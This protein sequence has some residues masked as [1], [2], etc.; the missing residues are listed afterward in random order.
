MIQ[1]IRGYLQQNPVLCFGLSLAFI[2]ATAQLVVS[3][4]YLAVLV[5]VAVAMIVFGLYR[6]QAAIAKS[7]DQAGSVAVSVSELTAMVSDMAR[8][9]SDQS[10]QIRNSLDQIRAVVNDATSK[11][12]VSFTGLNEKSQKQSQLVKG[13]IDDQGD[14]KG[15][16]QEFSVRVFV[17]ETDQ[18]LKQFIG[19]LVDSSEHGVKMAHTIDDISAHMD[20]A[21]KL[22]DDVS[23]IADQTNLLALNAAIEAARAGEA[24]RGFAVV[25]D[26]VRALSRNSNDFSLR[27]RS[28][29]Q[30]ARTDIDEA[31]GIINKMASK[32]VTETM[33]SKARVDDMLESMQKYDVL[34]GEEL[35][36]IS[37]VTEDISQSVNLAVRSLQFDDV[38]TQVIGYSQEHTGRLATLVEL[39]D[40][41]TRLVEKDINTDSENVDQA[42]MAFKE[43]LM[44]LKEEWAQNV[45]KAVDQ[46]SME[47]G[48][49][50]MF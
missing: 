47:Q 13:I 8:L 48:D 40:E 39:L 3:S 24:G 23:K 1:N 15:D 31:R 44:Q 20:K 2:T 36:K 5:L 27:I 49:I 45:N 41:Q 21:F 28:V 34:L 14:E 17:G 43:S 42:V 33:K 46:S 38:V 37:L 32:D 18:L 11:L 12:N 50:E 22:L 26:E 9:V 19:Q 30:E 10:Q 6:Q 35:N 7:E 25:A 4:V 16:S 29:V